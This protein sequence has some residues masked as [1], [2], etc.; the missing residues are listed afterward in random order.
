MVARDDE[1]R[2]VPHTGGLDRV[3]HR[4][5]FGGEGVGIVGDVV[6]E[7][8]LEVGQ[9]GIGVGGAR[10]RP[11]LGIVPIGGR[12]DEIAERGLH[13]RVLL[14][15]SRPRLGRQSLDD[16]NHFIVSRVLPSHNGDDGVACGRRE[17]DGGKPSR[18]GGTVHQD[19]AGARGAPDGA[20]G[21]SPLGGGPQQGQVLKRDEGG[22]IRPYVAV[23]PVLDGSRRV[24][25]D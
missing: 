3:V 16:V 11:S 14:G 1:D 5:G 10:G 18:L 6:E 2:L 7:V 12:V 24:G 21:S 17:L 13:E 19:G 20:D 4:P 9:V 22:G 23:S 25:S 15:D 8:S